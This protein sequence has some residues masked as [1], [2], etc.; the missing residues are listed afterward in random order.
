MVSYVI[1]EHEAHNGRLGEHLPFLLGVL[2]LIMFVELFII[3][4]MV[5]EAWV[6]GNG[7]MEVI[8]EATLMG[9]IQ[10]VAL[11]LVVQ[12]QELEA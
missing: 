6:L 5:T 2:S 10:R 12:L 3:G 11:N 1:S 7:S 4:C 9:T 8:S